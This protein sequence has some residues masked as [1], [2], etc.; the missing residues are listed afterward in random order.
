MYNFSAPGFS[1]ATGHFTQVIWRA[2]TQ[3]GVGLAFT[4]DQKTAY[5]VANYVV[6]GNLLG[7]FPANVPALC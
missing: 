3:L 1:S 6:P 5:A 4:S 7:A 2:S